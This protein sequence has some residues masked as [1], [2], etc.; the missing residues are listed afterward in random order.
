RPNRSNI[1]LFVNRRF[2]EDRTIAHAVVQAYHTLLPVGRYPLAVILIE[3]DSG[4]VDVNVH[5]QKT[6]V[7]FVDERAVFSAVQKAVRRAILNYGQVPDMTL[8]TPPPTQTPFA[9]RSDNA[10]SKSAWGNS[11]ASLAHPS[12]QPLDLFTSESVT[13]PD[14]RA[15]ISAPPTNQSVASNAS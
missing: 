4:Q 9:P 12:Q 11:Y 13:S 5:P 10:P 1:D 14:V 7:R 2:V 6:Q 8:P 3:I 15:P